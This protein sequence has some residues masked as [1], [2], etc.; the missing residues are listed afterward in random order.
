MEG[1]FSELCEVDEHGRFP[2]GLHE[3]LEV[4]N[5]DF[6]Q[7]VVLHRVEGHSLGL[8]YF[9]VH[10]HLDLV[11]LVV[12]QGKRIDRALLHSKH[13]AQDGLFAEPQIPTARVEV[14]SQVVDRELRV[15]HSRPKATCK[16]TMR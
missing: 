2:E 8:V 6:S 14:L 4:V 16:A 12:G 10:E 3:L 7:S 9:L 13:R 5:G 1:T 11:V 15:L